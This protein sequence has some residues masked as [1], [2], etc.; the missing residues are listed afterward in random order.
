[1]FSLENRDETLICMSHHFDETMTILISRFLHFNSKLDVLFI[2]V[3]FS[4]T[5]PTAYFPIHFV[6]GGVRMAYG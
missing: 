6:Q 5:F 3:F 1:M 2:L 4:S